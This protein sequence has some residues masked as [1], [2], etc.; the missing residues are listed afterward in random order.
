MSLIP[1]SLALGVLSN[2][3][4]EQATNYKTS[5]PVTIKQNVSGTPLASI[6]LDEDGT[7]P[8]SNP[9]NTDT[10]GVAA[11]YIEAGEYIAEY[12]DDLQLVTSK[13]SV[14]TSVL[15]NLGGLTERSDLAQRNR[16]ETTV[17]EIVTGVFSVG[18]KLTVTDRDNAKFNIVSGGTANGIDILDAGSGKTANLVVSKTLFAGKLGADETGANDDTAIIKRG[19]AILESI[20]GGELILPY[21]YSITDTITTKSRI[22]IDGLT[23]GG[24]LQKSNGIPILSSTGEG[25]V[26]NFEY[27]NLNLYYQTQQTTAGGSA[28]RL[29]KAGVFSYL[30]KLHGLNIKKPYHGIYCPE[31]TGS[32]SY[33]GTITNT[34]I[35]DSYSYGVKF[36]GDLAGANTNI[37]LDQVWCVQ[38]QGYETPT[39]SGFDLRRIQ[40]LNVG[41]IACDHVQQRALNVQTCTGTI[42]SLSVESC[43]YTYSSGINSIVNVSGGALRIENVIFVGNNLTISGDA[44]ITLILTNSGCKLDLGI[45][46]DLNN[47]INDTSSGKFLTIIG[48]DSSSIVTNDMY[49]G[50]TP[51]IRDA[52]TPRT[53][54]SFA[55]RSR[56]Q[57]FGGP[58][59]VAAGGFLDTGTGARPVD[60]DVRLVLPTSDTTAGVYP[61]ITEATTGGLLKIRYFNRLTGE[62]DFTTRSVMWDARFD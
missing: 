11:F 44:D 50:P 1:F 40:D 32:Q 49:V 48:F 12:Q 23:S 34:V 8:L 61:M 15:Q 51:V 36:L 26:R 5:T 53:I 29:S 33:L 60:A 17:A 25:S 2:D 10:R 18:D 52:N 27:R 39:S 47:V 19:V 30:Y 38:T 9:M 7:T 45:V 62:Q 35:E 14:S 55:G 21:I 57:Y 28:V 59:S 43:D 16:F 56:L 42:Q 13:F 37:D 24:L 6:Y 20:G 3:P 54:R 58:V 4:S 31:E 22:I 41:R 46:T